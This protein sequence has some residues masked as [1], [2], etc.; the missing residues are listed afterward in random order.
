[1]GKFIVKGAKNGGAVFNLLASNGEVIGTSEVYSS[2]A[3]ALKGVESVKKNAGA[4]VEDTTIGE[5]KKNPKYEI[6]QDK[7]GGYR[8]RLKATNG[9][10]ILS[11]EGYKAKDSAKKGA[12]SVAKNAPTAD[13]VEE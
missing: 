11:S 3:A 2:K 6:Y 4:D 12:A 13:I 9:E 7:G 10:I 5:S 1:M 8:F